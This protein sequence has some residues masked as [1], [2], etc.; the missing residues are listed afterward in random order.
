MQP[1]LRYPTTPPRKIAHK[2]QNPKLIDTGTG[3]SPKG[4]FNM[5]GEHHSIEIRC[6]RESELQRAYEIN[7]RYLDDGPFD[8]WAKACR[9]FPELCVACFREGKPIGIC[10]GSPFS[11][12]PG[13]VILDGIAV[14][15]NFS[16]QGYG[17]QLLRFFDQQIEHEGYEA[18]SLGSAGGYVEH[19]YM[20]NGYKPIEFAFWVP[21]DFDLS[22]ELQAKYGIQDNPGEDGTRRLSVRIGSLDNALR[23]RLLADFP[24]RE[25]ISI[26]YKRMSDYAADQDE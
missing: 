13:E 5:V 2:N 14:V 20:K 3:P 15:E 19:F 4:H 8:K 26:M 12:R 21:I 16:G 11:M 6:L 7:K 24:V 25:I 18:V 9:E 23:N 22:P 1:A 17:S 10:Y